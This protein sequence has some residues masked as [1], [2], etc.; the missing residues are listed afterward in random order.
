MCVASL[1]F[2][3][4]KQVQFWKNI[5]N[6]EADA[7]VA[8]AENVFKQLHRIVE[9]NSVGMIQACAESRKSFSSETQTYVNY[10]QSFPADE[11]SGRVD[12]L[13]LAMGTLSLISTN[14]CRLGCSPR[15]AAAAVK[16][17]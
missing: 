14:S 4:N 7:N 8:A 10:Q 13:L 11:R 12:P 1:M 5:C 9:E 2:S 15:N 6:P 16:V 17:R 3:C